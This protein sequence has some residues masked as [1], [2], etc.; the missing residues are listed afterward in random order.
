MHAWV[1]RVRYP[2]QGQAN[3][4]LHVALLS[5]SVQGS[6]KST[7]AFFILATAPNGS[8]G[9]EEEAVLVAQ[10]DGIDQCS[11]NK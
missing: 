5:H 9:I 3:R 6:S 2:I 10:S 7:L 11:A 1:S 4:P 8:T